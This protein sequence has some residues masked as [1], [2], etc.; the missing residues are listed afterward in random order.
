LRVKKT[1]WIVSAAATLRTYNTPRGSYGNGDFPSRWE[2]VRD[3]TEGGQGYTFVV[4]KSDGSD[5]NLYVL[6]RLKNP[7]RE[8]YFEREIEAC[9]A[10]GDPI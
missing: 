8:D 9:T 1:K 10:W 7:K 4:R 2:W 6:K 5:L 3:L